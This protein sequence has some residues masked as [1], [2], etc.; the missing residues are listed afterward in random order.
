MA[1]TLTRDAM[2]FS[3]VISVLA[4]L[5]SLAWLYVEPKFD[6]LVAFLVSL[7][8]LGSAYGYDYVKKYLSQSQK[9]EKN[10]TGIQAEGDV[11][12]NHIASASEQATAIN[13]TGTTTIVI[14][15]NSLTVEDV[16]RIAL[17]VFEANIIEFKGEAI[18]VAKNRNE[19]ITTKFISKLHNENPDGLSEFKSPDFLN[20]L[21][22]VQKEYA[23]SGDED[24]GELLIDLLI[25]RSRE[26]DR[27]F[28]QV[29]LNESLVVVSK[30][31]SEQISTLTVCFLIRHCRSHPAN[32]DAFSQYFEKHLTPFV[33][34]MTTT[35]GSF[36][37]LAST[38]CGSISIGEASLE[39][40]LRA[41]YSGLFNKGFDP[42]KIQELGLN[43]YPTMFVKCLNDN[44]KLQ[45]NALDIE[46]LN[47]SLSNLNITED[48]KV[49][50]KTLFESNIMSDAEIRE[51]AIEISPIFGELFPKWN[52]TSFKN[53][54]LDSIGISIG[55][56][57]LKRVLGEFSALS[58]WI[59]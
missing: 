57:N 10:A 37:H 44:A 19:Q 28:L 24:L 26:S 4:M 25:D 52:D 59:N 1:N 38:G 39:T 14:N 13:T 7:L 9:L 22:V 43:S 58:I 51:K 46:A 42:L 30:L 35:R 31:T 40:I 36:Q 32:H 16:K 11:T 27:S 21:F 48:H 45:V 12:G 3:K 2:I 54:M 34:L 47:V 49:A 29:V 20:S 41:N 56:A 18:G 50:I 8:A 6:S 17:E 53:F 55:H 23:K 5:A 33:H 15:Q